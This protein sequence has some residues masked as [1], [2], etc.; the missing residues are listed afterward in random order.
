MELIYYF[1]LFVDSNIFLF[2]SHYIGY[3]FSGAIL[4]F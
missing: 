4:L 3:L 1:L 2:F